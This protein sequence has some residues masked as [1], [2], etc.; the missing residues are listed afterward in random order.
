MYAYPPPRRP[1]TSLLDVLTS[2][3]VILGLLAVGVLGFVTAV[4]VWL[5][6]GE[7][8]SGA[9]VPPVNLTPAATLALPP[10]WDGK[11]RIN[12]LILGV[13]DRPWEPNWGPPRADTLIV[14]TLDPVTMSAGVISLPRDLWVTLPGIGE[15]KLNQTYSLSVPLYGREGA[16][17]YTANVVGDLLQIPIHH[18]AV[19]NFQA[20]IVFVDAIYGV[21]INVP[22]RMALDVVKANGERFDYPLYPGQQTLSGSLALA[23]ARYRSDA[24]GDFGRM[25]RQQQILE[26][27]FRRL[28]DPRILA[29]LALEAP[30]LAKQLQGSLITDISVG[31]ALRLA[32]LVADVPRENV[33]FAVIDQRHATPATHW[34]NGVPVYALDPDREKILAVRDQ[35]FFPEPKPTSTP[36]PAPTP[37]VGEQPTSEATPLPSTPTPVSDQQKLAAALQEEPQLMVQNGTRI[38]ALACRTGVLLQELGFPSVETGNADDEYDAT[39][40]LEY[41][42]RPATRAFLQDFFDVPDNRVRYLADNNP[43]ADIVVVLGKDWAASGRVDDVL[44]AGW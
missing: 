5:S 30:A 26:A 14:L 4:A 8:P 40:L 28:K 29:E 38:A 43:P 34:E 16:A 13:D 36:R 31:D 7:A 42:A 19:V 12:M 32:R 21:N 9:A 27:A 41:A 39:V 20:F 11:E 17:R 24:D 35:V 3:K 10:R 1:R 37:T 23:Y 33:H 15:R 6:Q 18:Y 22:K 25:R 2:G 44:C